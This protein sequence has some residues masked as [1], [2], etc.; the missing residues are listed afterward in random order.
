MHER[1]RLSIY[2]SRRIKNNPTWQSV[3][4]CPFIKWIAI[5]WITYKMN[6][7]AFKPSGPY[8]I[9]IISFFIAISSFSIAIL[10]SS[11]DERSVDAVANA[12]AWS[13]FAVA[14]FNELAQASFSLS[15]LLPVP[16]CPA[17]VLSL[18]PASVS[19]KSNTASSN[20][21]TPP[22]HE[23]TWMVDCRL[24]A[25][26]RK[27]REAMYEPA[28]RWTI[29]RRRDRRASSSGVSRS[30]GSTVVVSVEGIME[31]LGIVTGG[32]REAHSLMCSSAIFFS[33]LEWVFQTAGRSV[34][35]QDSEED[36][37]HIPSSG[38]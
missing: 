11:L 24:W 26:T 23:L 13:N 33:T 21:A 16:Y 30:N 15:L 25:S 31:G 14:F 20:M 22:I 3:L 19:F 29:P 38:N 32:V 17:L 28:V 6:P 9:P 5:T 12:N 4:K 1:H 18:V 35:G 8:A 7:P 2:L 36:N 10:E 37:L 27:A 34:W